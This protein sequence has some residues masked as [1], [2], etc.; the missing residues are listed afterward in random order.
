L[1]AENLF[2]GFGKM[3]YFD[4]LSVEI[5][6]DLYPT[7]DYERTKENPNEAITTPCSPCSDS[8]DEYASRFFNELFPALGI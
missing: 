4:D 2:G 6:D 5:T 7:S 8:L 3:Q 1:N